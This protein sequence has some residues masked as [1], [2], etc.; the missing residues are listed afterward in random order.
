M[1][2]LR[3]VRTLRKTL[4]G[5][6]TAS[7]SIALRVL[8]PFRHCRLIARATQL[9]GTLRTGLG[10]LFQ[11]HGQKFIR[12]NV[13]QLADARQ[14]RQV[15]R[16]RAA[17]PVSIP[18][19]LDAKRIGKILGMRKAR[20]FASGPQPLCKCLHDLFVKPLRHGGDDASPSTRPHVNRFT[21]THDLTLPNAMRKVNLL[22][23]A[24]KLWRSLLSVCVTAH[25]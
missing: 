12:L 19:R 6:K 22:T 8:H 25:F 10:A 20:I 17:L 11:R 2:P 13:Q 24:P 9:R 3:Q 23:H 15:R 5:L 16:R 21:A 18:V 14:H 7:T 4:S 1:L